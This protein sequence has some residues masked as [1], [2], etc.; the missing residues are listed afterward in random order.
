MN[1]DIENIKSTAKITKINIVKQ[2]EG[3]KDMQIFQ[4]H[5][6]FIKH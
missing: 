6:T 2:L 4:A 5:R 1:K 3:V